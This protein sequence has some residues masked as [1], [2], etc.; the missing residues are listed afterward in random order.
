MNKMH[1]L[2]G[3]FFLVVII[4]LSATAAFSPP[5]STTTGTLVPHFHRQSFF[6]RIGAVS[7]VSPLCSSN[8]KDEQKKG[9]VVATFTPEEEALMALDAT[10]STKTTPNCPTWDDNI[11]AMLQYK[12]IYNSTFIPTNYRRC[13]RYPRLGKWIRNLRR[14]NS[15]LTAEQIQSL[16]PIG[17]TWQTL[18]ANKI[19][20]DQRW[21]A[22]YKQILQYRERYGHCSV[23][24]GWKENRKLATW[25]RDQRQNYHRHVMPK[26][27]IQKLKDIGFVWRIYPYRKRNVP[28]QEKQWQQRYQELLEFRQEFGHCRVPESY[29][30]VN[31][32]LERWVRVQREHRNMGLLSQER[33]ELLNEIDFVWRGNK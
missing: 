31:Q 1:V 32:P 9:Q 33:Q 23:P 13:V 19:L 10:L 14:R 11:A 12:T 27:R 3:W 20:Y 28:K 5:L 16:E 6:F 8:A 21:D 2:C 24:G 7:A 25:V 26:D 15:P 17:F 22:M 30:D 29:R 18:R 4:T